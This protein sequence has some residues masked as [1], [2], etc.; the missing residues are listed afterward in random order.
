M[1]KKKSLL[2]ISLSCVVIGLALI[3][4]LAGFLTHIELRRRSSESEYRRIKGILQAKVYSE[5]IRISG[6]TA[7]IESAGP[8][9]GKPIVEGKIDNGSI[10]NIS[11]MILKIKF[12]DSEG[13]DIYEI[14]LDALSPSLGSKNFASAAIAYF[15]GASNRLPK[16][17]AKFFKMILQKCPKE[18][19]DTLSKQAASG[20]ARQWPGTLDFEILSVQFVS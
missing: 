1:I 18:I 15:Q 7:R 19:S 14:T 20:A 8:L 9:N 12:R 11:S 5:M 6:L 10:K 17:S 13:A 2:V 3:F 16:H 4:T